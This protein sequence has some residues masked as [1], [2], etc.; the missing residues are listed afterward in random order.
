MFKL[1]ISCNNIE[2]ISKSP[3]DNDREELQ[4]FDFFNSF[5]DT[6]EAGGVKMDWELIDV[7]EDKYEEIVKKI[8]IKESLTVGDTT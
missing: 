6:K 3:Y 2:R 7:V 1:Y 4:I 8:G 5:E